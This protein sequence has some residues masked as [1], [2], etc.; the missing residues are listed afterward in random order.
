MAIGIKDEK[1]F[2]KFLKKLTPVELMALAK[3][4]AEFMEEITGLS[5]LD[6]M[7]KHKENK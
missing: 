5:T 3:A 1:Y 7:K 2:K 6:I 4:M